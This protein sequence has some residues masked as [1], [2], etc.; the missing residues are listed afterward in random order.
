MGAPRRLPDS[1]ELRRLRVVEKKTYGEIA[2]MYGVTKQAVHLALQQ[3]KLV[4]PRPRYEDEIPWRIAM[5]HAT[6][7]VLQNLRNA[8]RLKHGLKTSPPSKERYVRNWLE[9]LDMP[10]DGAPHGVV[11]DYDRDYYEDGFAYVP[12]EESDD[13]IIRR[14]P[15]DG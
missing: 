15:A 7:G 3:A 10:R 14:P 1:D 6:S 11:V 13:W 12:R 4:K 8:A 5:H 9:K 2:E